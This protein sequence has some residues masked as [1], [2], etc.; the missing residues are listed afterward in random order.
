GELSAACTT[1]HGTSACASACVQGLGN[2]DLHGSGYQSAAR[3]LKRK[4]TGIWTAPADRR[5][6]D[7]QLEGEAPQAPRGNRLPTVAP[8]QCYSAWKL[9]FSERSSF[10]MLSRLESSTASV[11]S[12]P[13]AAPA[14]SAKRSAIV[15]CRLFERASRGTPT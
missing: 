2:R 3:R 11:R 7:A 10:W 1:T 15:S 12:G 9:I 14:S 8:I 4:P 5:G 13:S 6:P